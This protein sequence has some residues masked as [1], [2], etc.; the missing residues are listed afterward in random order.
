MNSTWREVTA[1]LRRDSPDG[2]LPPLLLTLTV[3]TLAV[4]VGLLAPVSFFAYRASRSSP[5]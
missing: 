4:A 3:V 2:P 1:T 5:Q